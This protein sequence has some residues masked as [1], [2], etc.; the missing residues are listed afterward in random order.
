MLAGK[1]VTG[2]HRLGG[3][4]SGFIPVSDQDA[5][6]TARQLT[7]QEG[8]FGGTSSGADVVAALQRAKELGRGKRIVTVICDSGLKYLE[9]KLY[10]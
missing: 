5:L 9:G 7:R 1:T 10:K 6:E 2:V 4:G 8:N 3:M